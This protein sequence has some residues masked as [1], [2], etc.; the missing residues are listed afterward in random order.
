VKAVLR[1]RVHPGARRAGLVGWMAVGTLKLGGT[2][3]PEDG[4]ANRAVVGLIAATLG[5]REAAV[6]VARGHGAR[7]KV[8]EVDGLDE[9]TVRARITAALETG[10]AAGGRKRNARDEGGRDDGG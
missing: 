1:L 7:T 9:Q 10:A 6:Q 2:A 3:P 8:V 5:V 4:R